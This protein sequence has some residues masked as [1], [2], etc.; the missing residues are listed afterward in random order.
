MTDQKPNPTSTRSKS[1]PQ[2]TERTWLLRLLAGIS[3]AAYC[4]I[5]FLST[6]F[7]VNNPPSDR[8]IVLV[9]SL[10]GFLF[11]IY[12][13]AVLVATKVKQNSRLVLLIIAAAVVFRIPM[14]FSTPIQEVDIYRYMWDGIV[15]AQGIS[16][17]RYPPQAVMSANSQ[18]FRD[19]ELREL[20]S[21]RDRQPAIAEV[22]RRVHFR[23]LPTIY[24]A[25]SQA[26]FYCA[27]VA[28]PVD[29]SLTTR[30]LI[31]KA[32]LI[33]FDLA[34]LFLVIKLLSLARMPIGLSILY[35]WCPLVMKEVANSGHLDAIAV[36]LCTLSV[37]L[38]ARLFFSEQSAL[39]NRVKFHANLILVA[40]VL[41]AAVGAKLY[42]VVLAPLILFG[43]A[44]RFGWKT[45]GAPIVAFSLATFFLLNP[46]LPPQFRLD[47]RTAAATESGEA[48]STGASNPD[49]PAAN[50]PSRGVTAFFKSWEM[51]DFVFMIL[52]EN[53]K[54]TANNQSNQ[55]VWFSVFPE[56]LRQSI[57][58]AVARWFS[59]PAAE[60]PFSA[61]FL[62]TRIVTTL[63]FLC[64][65]LFLAWKASKHQSMALVCEAAFL[66]LAWFW[67]L[68][69]TQNPWYWLWALPLLPFARNRAWI[70]ISGLVLVYYL[71][72]WLDYCFA[73]IDVL[74]TGYRGTAFFDFV[75]TW[76]EFA[77]WF[78][79]LTIEYFRKDDS[80][81]TD[82]AA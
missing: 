58:T 40:L 43:T 6:E 32:S 46:M 60:A 37:Y 5:L 12:V 2:K 64:I 17:F 68:L 67:L 18:D 57:A 28:T 9:M 71:R 80:A 82:C 69:P 36:F 11:A 72:F 45:V 47:K 44:R 73:N 70:A 21:L 81:K 77:P 61:P 1:I 26:V 3:S 39:Q 49:Q 22:L 75:V 53:L 20:A 31:M 19:R 52:V 62:L 34:T 15:S 42:P 54:P 8:P 33:A 55:P 14:L 79:W 35:G 7:T 38:I 51:N 59:I 30:L 24:P 48:N 74:G 4:V 10:F 41:A 16:P 27:A 66:T 29:A 76:I 65:A 13:L 56:E 78:L 23:E 63:A 50:D 25:T